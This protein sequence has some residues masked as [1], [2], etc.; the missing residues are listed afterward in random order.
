MLRAF[1]ARLQPWRPAPELDPL[2]AYGLWAATYPPEAYNPL[3]RAEEAAV[4]DLLPREGVRGGH[5]LDLA[6]GSGRY[7][8]H[9]K[10][11]GAESVAGLDL[12]VEMLARARAFQPDLVRATML[13]LPLSSGSFHLI[14]CGLA[15]GHLPDL[16]PAM[17]EVGRVLKPGGVVIYSD[18]HP[19][20]HLAGWKRAFHANGREYTVQHHLH[21]YAEHHAA[22]LGAGLTIEALREP[23]ALDESGRP[24]WGNAPVVLVVRARKG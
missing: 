14:L 19:F 16:A 21:L 11:R 17:R 6:C 7:L 24:A 3:M 9:L 18:F 22:C 23:R 20:G 8:R 5:A 1:L 13:S 4:L 15:V 2:T 10:E 12:S